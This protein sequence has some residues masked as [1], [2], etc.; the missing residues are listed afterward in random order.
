MAG[1]CDAGYDGGCGMPCGGGHGGR[2][3]HHGGGYR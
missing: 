1:P 3:F 2:L